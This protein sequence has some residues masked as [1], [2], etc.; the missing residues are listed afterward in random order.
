[1][2]HD[3]I[4]EELDGLDELV[5]ALLGLKGGEQAVNVLE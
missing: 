4:G 5:P 1:M 2:E 3:V